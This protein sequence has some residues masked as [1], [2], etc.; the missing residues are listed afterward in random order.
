MSGHNA[1]KEIYRNALLALSKSQPLSKI[2]VKNILDSTG[3]AKQTFY[4][5][6]AD[7]YDLINYVMVDFLEGI[8]KTYAMHTFSGIMSTLKYCR[9]HQ[10]FFTAI[11]GNYCQNNF[12]DYFWNWCVNYY[13]SAIKRNFGNGSLSDEVRM[14]IR[15]YCHG[16]VGI[17]IDWMLDGMKDP[18]ELIAGAIVKSRPLIL[19]Q[20][21][22][23]ERS[24]Q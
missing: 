21:F 1:T 19:H 6:F 18:D 8:E 2:T 14:S 13:V 20:Y 11:A 7:K 17:H 4:N 5:H 12:R 9:E 23:I 16:A 3:T 22:P 10:R 24:I 15:F